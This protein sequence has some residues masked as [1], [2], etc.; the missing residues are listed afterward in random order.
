MKS[1]FIYCS[2]GCSCCNNENH[3]RGPF[4][5]R[6]VAEER[7]KYYREHPILASQYAKRGV[8][9]IEPW[10]QLSNGYET[11]QLPDGRLIINDRVY[12]G[13]VDNLPKGSDLEIDYLRDN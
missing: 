1:F 8:Y 12:A 2:T 5:S 9:D 7:I 11:E 6:S 13:Y 10:E 4:S 3:Y